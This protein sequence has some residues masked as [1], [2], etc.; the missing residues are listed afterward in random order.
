MEENE[1][2]REPSSLEFL[3]V[4]ECENERFRNSRQCAN[5]RFLS[6][7]FLYAS[8]MKILVFAIS[9]LPSLFFWPT[10]LPSLNLLVFHNN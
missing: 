9:H 8:H 6:L 1:R 7:A 10:H 4:S 3:L 5:L 2:I